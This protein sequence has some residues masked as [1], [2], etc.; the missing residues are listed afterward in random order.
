MVMQIDNYCSLITTDIRFKILK[1]I[2]FLRFTPFF[3]SEEKRGEEI[4]EPE[5]LYIKIEK[6]DRFIIDSF[7]DANDLLDGLKNAKYNE[8]LANI[9]SEKHRPHLTQN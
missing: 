6:D 8:R 9:I 1:F 5:N 7:E 4:I 3:E 2:I